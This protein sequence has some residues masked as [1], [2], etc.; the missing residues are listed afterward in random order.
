MIN[1]P[2]RHVYSRWR[3]SLGRNGY[4]HEPKLLILCNNATEPKKRAY[5]KNLNEDP[6][7]SLKELLKRHCAEEKVLR[8]LKEPVTCCKGACQTSIRKL[9][10]LKHELQ[11]SEN[12]VGKFAVMFEDTTS[13]DMEGHSTPTRT[14]RSV[15]CTP[16][17]D[18][19]ACTIAES[20]CVSV[21]FLLKLICHSIIVVTF[22][23]TS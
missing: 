10:K 7:F 11:T 18:T 21:S 14:G 2:F 19:L 9:S 22:V 6:L 16:E 4:K 5:L 17:R 13:I 20:P 15:L 8:C 1:T 23:G 12:D 3:F